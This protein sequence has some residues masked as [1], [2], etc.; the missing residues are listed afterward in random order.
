MASVDMS[1]I[2]FYTPPF[3]SALSSL[4][5][6]ASRFEADTV[7]TDDYAHSAFDPELVQFDMMYFVSPGLDIHPSF[8]AC[9]PSVVDGGRLLLALSPMAALR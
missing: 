3:P 7:A 1:F 4:R 8:K 6:P 5:I 9:P 2:D